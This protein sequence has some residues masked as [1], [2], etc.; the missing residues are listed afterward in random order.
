MQGLFDFI[1]TPEGQG[2]FGALAGYA[3]NASR[4]S[5]VNSIG[6]GGLAGLL[7]YGQGLDRQERVA[8]NAQQKQLRDL[9]MQTTM[10]AL[11]KTRFEA[12]QAE[13]MRRAA[14]NAYT[15]ATPAAGGMVDGMLPPEFQTG[16][17]PAPG[18]PASFDTKGFL[19]QV[20]SIDPMRGMEWQ[21][22]LKPEN[23][24]GK[25]DPKDYTP[26]SVQKF[27]A[28]GNHADLIP[29]RKLDVVNN[30][31]VNLYETQP[32]ATFD[33]RDPN[34]PFF[35]VGGNVV[36]N[37]QYQD[38]AIQR[39]TASAPKMP[40][41]NLHDP[42]AVAKAAMDMQNQVRTAFK[43]HYT[44]ADQYGAIQA[45]AKNPSPQ[46]DTALLYSFFK[47][48]DPT[49]TVREGEVAMV[50]DNRSIPDK[51]KGMAQKLAGGGSLLPHER[52]DIMEQARRQVDA[53]VPRARNE[54]QAYRDN[55]KRLG[56]DPDLYV[57][58]PY[59][60]FDGGNQKPKAVPL[61][62][63]APKA[64]ELTKGTTYN[65]PRGPAVWDGMKFNPV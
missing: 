64:S 22:K 63:A 17:A 41:I 3:A 44:I 40:A 42:T 28:T 57:P 23:P 9:Q 24:F 11:D 52:E 16:A 48:L 14:S 60:G 30:R 37:Q 13:R 20:M 43:D 50:K 61:P 36:P 65:T 47:V 29:A 56:L 4:T 27:A 2:L 55:A 25:V 18:R 35:S 10:A 7:S 39:A 54:L 58:D 62:S 51:F 8:E 34:Q 38:F 31:A 26:A 33:Q 21:A 46:G 1:K 59:K 12:E 19:G 6:R 49:S 32:G 45:A 5:P 15:P 53:R